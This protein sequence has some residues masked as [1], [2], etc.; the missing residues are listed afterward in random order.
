MT[1]P[2][3]RWFASVGEPLADEVAA[4]VAAVASALPAFVAPSIERVG[5]AGDALRAL[6]AIDAE[7]SWWE[8][9]ETARE[10]LWE[11]AAERLGEDALAFAIAR[12]NAADGARIAQVALPEALAADPLLAEAAHEAMLLVAH[13]AALADAAG[14]E[15]H[16]F[17]AQRD[18]FV[19][20]HWLLGV[21]GGRVIVY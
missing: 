17:S 6:R 4:A 10:A 15:A 14:A 18:V 9:Q 20:G 19:A 13:L 16:W 8:V 12:A 11:A 7:G 2:A 5:S 3:P 21:H 1:P